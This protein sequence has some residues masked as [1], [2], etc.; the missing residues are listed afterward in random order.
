M[1]DE[2]IKLA[3]DAVETYIRTGKIMAPP[4]DLPNKMSGRKAGVFTSIHTDSGEL[5]GCIGTFLPCQKSITLEIIHNAISAATQDPRFPPIT[6]D[7]LPNL[8]YSVDILSEP[9]PVN[10]ISCLNPK[11][12]GLIVSTP[13]GRRGLLLPDLEDVDKV[14]Q[15]IEICRQ[16]GG[17][18]T[19]EPVTLYRFTVERHQ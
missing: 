6:E 11:A 7:E 5:R 9:K 19:N 10:D 13:D 16:K 18:D 4:V 3:R 12:C 15:Q 14:E 8:I 1:S 2:F 17:I